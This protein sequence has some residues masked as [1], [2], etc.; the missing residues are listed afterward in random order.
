MATRW[1]RELAWNQ[2]F[3]R[4][5][6]QASITPDAVLRGMRPRTVSFKKA[7]AFGG[8]RLNAMRTTRVRYRPSPFARAA[9]LQIGARVG[10]AYIGYQAGVYLGRKANSAMAG[11]K[12]YARTIKRG[13]NVQQ[14][15]I[16]RKGAKQRSMKA[17]RY[18]QRAAITLQ[19]PQ[20][21]QARRVARNKASGG[22][23]RP[24]QLSSAQRAAM[25]R[26]RGRDSRGKF[27]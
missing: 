27:R 6:G 4:S 7:G 17:S 16:A 18:T 9:A 3:R 23:R 20:K 25:A 12:A 10:G 13:G 22:G 24:P 5:M 11:R 26:R 1:E 8:P 15:T 2:E 19:N 21:Y 14:A